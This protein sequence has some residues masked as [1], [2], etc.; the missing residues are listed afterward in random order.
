METQKYLELS[1]NKSTADQTFET[2]LKGH[3]EVNL[4]PQM[5]ILEMTKIRNQ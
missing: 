4:V 3:S 5:N 1:E 2:K